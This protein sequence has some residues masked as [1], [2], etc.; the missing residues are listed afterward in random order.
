MKKFHLCL[1]ATC[2]VEISVPFVG[3]CTSVDSIGFMS[4]SVIEHSLND[5]ARSISTVIPHFS[6]LMGDL[7]SRACRPKPEPTYS[8][9]IS[10]VP[11]G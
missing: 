6:Y 1:S 10:P 11:I 2:A 9:P 3:F 8:E 4:G 7:M 5:G